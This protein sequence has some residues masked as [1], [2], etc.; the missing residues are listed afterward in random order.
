MKKYQPSNG[1]EGD[2]F[3]RDW[4]CKCQRDKSMRDGDDFDECDDNELCPIIADTFAYKVSDEKY[5]KEWTYGKYGAPCCT[6]FVPAGDSIPCPRCTRTVDMFE[7]G[8]PAA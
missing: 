2:A 3:F 4:C 1:T 6:A 8:E 7:N 5:P